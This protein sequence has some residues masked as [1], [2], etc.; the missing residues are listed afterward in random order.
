MRQ[1]TDR[2]GVTPPACPR[3]GRAVRP[4]GLFSSDW[5]CDEHGP[6]H[7]LHVLPTATPE[8]VEHV[9]AAAKVPYWVPSPMLPGWTVTGTGWAGDER[10]GARATVLA[11]AGPAP[12]GG[13]ADLVLVAE[14]P[15]VGLGAGY[16]G[17]PVTAAMPDLSG[18]P[19]AKV[20]AG[21]H[22]TALWT[23]ATAPADRAVLAGE[24]LGVWLWA[25]LWPAEAGYVLL[26]HVVLHDM[27]DRVPADLVVGAPS[28][29]LVRLPP[30]LP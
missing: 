7:P 26:E 15:G 16:A 30:P 22:P 28:P 19:A 21:G 5:Q 10:S 23:V 17:L 27:R 18:P 11:C 4:P 20:H 29:Y 2:G 8:A 1:H 24:A 13:V 12:L 6:V 14:E 25:V 9:R 3:C